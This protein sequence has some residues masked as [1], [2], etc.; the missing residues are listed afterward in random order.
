M[1]RP[2]LHGCRNR[3]PQ[4]P[5]A[6]AGHKIGFADPLP[7]NVIQHGDRLA[8]TGHLFQTLRPPICDEEIAVFVKGKP[9]GQAALGHNQ[10]L[11]K[12]GFLTMQ[13]MMNLLSA[14]GN[15]VSSCWLKPV[16]NRF[17]SIGIWNI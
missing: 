1:I 9:I 12:T 2:R 6:V 16:T 14:F 11:G 7:V 8:R 13:Q 4:T 5:P 17:F 10:P 3:Q 15:S